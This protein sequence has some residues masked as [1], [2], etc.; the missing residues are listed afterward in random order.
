MFQPGFTLP[1]TR[2]A[3]WRQAGLWLMVWALMSG[4][5]PASAH[6]WVGND[7]TVVLG[8]SAQ[9]IVGL[10]QERVRPAVSGDWPDA[11]P[12]DAVVGVPATELI[13][14]TLFFTAMTL[15]RE[16]AESPRY[17]NHSPRS[18]PRY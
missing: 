6:Q 12:S 8:E 16:F 11:D 1:L 13:P 17:L 18:P 7:G 3:F 2:G 15:S 4:F 9:A 5:G 10:Q 14:Q